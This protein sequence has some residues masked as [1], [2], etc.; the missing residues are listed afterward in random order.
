MRRSIFRSGS[1]SRNKPL[2]VAVL[3][4]LLLAIGAFLVPPIRNLLGIV[5]LSLQ[6]WGVVFGVAL[7]LIVVVEIGKLFSNR[8]RNSHVVRVSQS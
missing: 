6:Q 8:L 5:P 2:I 7:S 4:G 3:A 1:L